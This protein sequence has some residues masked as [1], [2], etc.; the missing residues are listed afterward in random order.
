[1]LK[2]IKE[3]I[4]EIKN[5][6]KTVNTYKDETIVQ[7]LPT[8][9]MVN[10][11]VKLFENNKFDEAKEILNKALDI[12][13]NDALIYKYL[14]K[15]SEKEHDFKLAVEH[16]DKSSKLNPNDKE[17]WLKLGMC[18][19]YSNMLDESIKSFDRANKINPMNTDIYTGRGMAL[20]QQKKYAQALDNFTKA[21]Q[22][23]KY[24]YTAILLSSVMEIR[25]GQYSVAE[26]K[27]NFLIKTAPNES[28]FYEYANLKLIQ[29]KY[30]EAEIYAQKAID[31]NKQMLP[32]YFILGKIY[33]IRKDTPK[34]EEIFTNALKVGL[35][36]STLYLE[37]AKNYIKVFEFEKS[38]YILNNVL[39]LENN[40][41]EAK[42]CLALLNSYQNDF[43]LLDELSHKHLDNLY[44]QEAL[45]VKYFSEKDFDKA[46]ELFK[47]AIKTDKHQTYIYYE[48]A[49]TYSKKN[50]NYKTNEYFEKFVTANPKYVNGLLEYSKW[51]INIS[52]Y[53][54]ANRK[55]RKAISLEP[56]NLEILNLLFFTKYTLAKNN[57]SEYNIKEAIS[58]ANKSLELGR[59]DY[60][61][62]KEELEK[63]LESMQGN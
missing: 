40:N 51:L 53:E 39:N 35:E 28:S 55:L 3:I 34:I 15:I 57:I 19:L 8:L 60:P 4:K 14:G 54:E 20:M 22:I 45:G 16:F 9:A 52:D 27:L 38:R 1:M 5:L 23:S 36:S 24:N 21:Y 59:F 17:I 32:A 56:D 44:I 62:E 48:L 49:K 46:S 43:T 10:R 47:K 41:I 33:S 26:E 13:D 11:A 25:L 7:S 29:E 30:D 31:V 37:W 61:K 42:L 63:M 6:N 18:Q 50:D 2:K 12:S 58:I